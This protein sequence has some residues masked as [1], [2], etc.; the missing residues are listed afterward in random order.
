MIEHLVE[1]GTE[2]WFKVRAGIPTAS[3]FDKII[4]P[5]GM[6]SKQFVDYADVLLAERILGKPLDRFQ[7]AKP[8]WMERGNELEAD[9]EQTY[10]FMFDC[11][12]KKAGFCTLDD[13]SAG[14]SPDRFV[15]EDGLLEIKCPAPWTHVANLVAEKIDNS[16]I[17]QVQGQLYVTG[18]KWC[19]WFSYHPDM[20]P[21]C[22][23]IERDEEYIAKL[24]TALKEFARKMNAQMETL[25]EKGVI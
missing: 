10:E 11:T 6:A 20:T 14:C 8:Y 2:E 12:T 18:R 1:Q 7:D 15:G 17:P 13:G 3:N 23:R 24:D 21:S 5:T 4:T 25:K 22:I 16:Y 19:D 9:A